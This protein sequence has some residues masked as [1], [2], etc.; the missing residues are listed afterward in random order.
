MIQFLFYSDWRTLQIIDNQRRALP[1][2]GLRS[3]EFMISYRYPEPQNHEAHP[4]I[5]LT[6]G[7]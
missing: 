1:Q 2:L 5:L 4:S 3:G 6:Q 7:W